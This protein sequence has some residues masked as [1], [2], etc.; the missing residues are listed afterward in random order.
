MVFVLYLFNIIYINPILL[1]SLCFIIDAYNI[2]FIL[3]KK[4]NINHNIIN[5][6]RLFLIISFHY[7]P[8]FFLLK[9][10]KSS[11]FNNIIIS[12]PYLIILIIIYIFYLKYNKL[13]LYSV[14][15]YII[16]KE[17]SNLSDY[18]KERFNTTFEFII[19]IF[20]SLYV[21]YTVITK[22]Y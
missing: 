7:I 13:D 20:L 10:H 19:L 18:I 22:K 5:F 8:I 16:T 1:Y 21:N 12:I 3:G 2:I 17:Y 4:I 15:N 11:D 9:T 14:Y 6:L